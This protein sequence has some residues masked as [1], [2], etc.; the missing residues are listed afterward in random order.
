[1]IEYS[2][3]ISL[4]DAK[5]A[6]DMLLWLDREHLAAVCAAGALDARVVRLD[7]PSSG[8]GG[9]EGSGGQGVTLVARYRFASRAA[10]ARY[11]REHAPRLRAEGLARFPPEAGVRYDRSIADIVAEAPTSFAG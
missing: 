7:P 11:E 6:A 5:T 2:V 4:P 10:F 9:G 8:E 1:M 3:R